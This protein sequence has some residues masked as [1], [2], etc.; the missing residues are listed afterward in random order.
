[1][2]KKGQRGFLW[3]DYVPSREWLLVV[4]QTP[5]QTQQ[6]AK[7]TTST[8]GEITLRC[9]S[10]IGGNA[11]DVIFELTMPTMAPLRPVQPMMPF[12]YQH[13]PRTNMSPS[14]CYGMKFVRMRGYAA[15]FCHQ[16]TTGIKPEFVTSLSSVAPE[17]VNDVSCDVH[18]TIHLLHRSTMMNYVI[19]VERQSIPL[20][21]RASL[22]IHFGSMCDM[23]LTSIPG[24]HLGLHE[25]G[26]E[27]I[28]IKPIV[29]SGMCC[30][31][32]CVYFRRTFTC[33]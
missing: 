21:V 23:L 27:Q 20:D 8:P 26:P 17:N 29:F 2:A 28:P 14:S 22:R 13:L 32:E 4:Y 3:W 30:V 7:S 24:V 1:M 5:K 6:T 31:E 15:C 33:I 9:M 25:F 18:A 19:K 10:L 16:Y 12:E 11:L